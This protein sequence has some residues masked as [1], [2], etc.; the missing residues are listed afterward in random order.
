MDVRLK[1]KHLYAFG[2]YRLDALERVLLRDGQPVILP[3]K[4]LETLLVLVERAGHIVEK[5]ELLEKVWPSVFVEEGNLARHIFNLRQVL[6]DTPDGRKY[7]ETIPKRGYRFVAAVH[8]DQEPGAA[9]PAAPQTS[10]PAPLAVPAPLVQKRNFWLWPITLSV[11]GAGGILIGHHFWPPRNVPPQRAMLAVLP[12]VNLSGDAHED[13]FADGLTEEM[14]AQLGQLQPAQLG[15]IARTSTVRYKDTKETAAQISPELG[16]G[17]LL[18]G[19]VRRGADRPASMRLGPQ[20][21]MPQRLI[22]APRPKSCPAQRKRRCKLLRLTPTWE[23]RTSGLA[24]CACFTIGIGPR[25]K[26][27]IVALSKSTQAC[28]KR[29]WVT[30]ITWRHWDTS[31]KR[32]LAYSKPIFSIRWH[33]KAARKR[34]GST[35]SPVECRRRWSRPRKRSSWNQPL[36]FLMRCSRWPR[37]RWGSALKPFRLQR[38]PC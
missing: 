21:T 4:D 11:L 24:M 29:N 35:T 19:A 5:E 32:S 12:F 17:H 26:G 34:F 1:S 30:R 23:A 18:E 38:T 22:T 15:P 16:V 7:I 13:Y 6:G 2:S 9:H 36:A 27:N 20:R 31:I 25:P 8:E 3:P 37:H 14:I 28:R 33:S 10:E